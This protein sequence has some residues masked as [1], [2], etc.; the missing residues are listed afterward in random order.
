LRLVL[1]RGS[2]CQLA[3]SRN[4]YRTRALVSITPDG[5]G[6]DVFF[7]ETA[8]REGDEIVEGASVEYEA[9]TDKKTGKMKAIS[10]DLK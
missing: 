8:L 5:G 4:G 6:P 7:H 3:K 2:R 9:G 1:S 10:V